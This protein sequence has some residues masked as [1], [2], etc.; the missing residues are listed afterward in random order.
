M[1]VAG[2]YLLIII[3]EI[4]GL[5][6]KKPRLVKGCNLTATIFYVLMYIFGIIALIAAVAIASGN[7]T[8]LKI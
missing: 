8:F 3:V 5:A 6:V 2:L 7:V 1:V 4:I